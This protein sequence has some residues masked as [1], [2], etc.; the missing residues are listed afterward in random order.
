MSKS[1]PQ[2]YMVSVRGNPNYSLKTYDELFDKLF[3]KDFWKKFHLCAKDKNIIISK[4]ANGDYQNIPLGEKALT[5]LRSLNEKA[6]KKGLSP[7]VSISSVNQVY[8][9][10]SPS[11]PWLIRLKCYYRIWSE[12]TVVNL[13][14]LTNGG[15]LSLVN[16]AEN[17]E[18]L[19][20][21]TEITFETLVNN[22]SFLDKVLYHDQLV[23]LLKK[24]K[25]VDLFE[26]YFT[27]MED[28]DEGEV[29]LVINDDD[30]SEIHDYESRSDFE[31]REV[32]A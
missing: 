10:R 26:D 19:D 4:I 14:I 18:E 5:L 30:I 2:T 6:L 3:S 16:L 24:Y 1:N 22:M 8:K 29:V 27:D 15:L 11:N 31:G 7:V 28:E 21:L 17:S 25:D 9:Q 12:T 32:Y 13:S 20:D 23:A